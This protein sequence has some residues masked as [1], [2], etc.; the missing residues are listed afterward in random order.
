MRVLR[1]MAVLPLALASSALSAQSPKIELG[2]DIARTGL[3]SVSG[4][5]GYSFAIQCA[6]GSSKRAAQDPGP[7]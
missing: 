5:T 4:N 6:V 7:C 3:T 1:L 2:V